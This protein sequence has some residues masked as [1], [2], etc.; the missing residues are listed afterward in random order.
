MHLPRV[1][2]ILVIVSSIYDVATKGSN[3]LQELILSN[4]I[5]RRS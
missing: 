2:R 1:A 3:T 4:L 5:M